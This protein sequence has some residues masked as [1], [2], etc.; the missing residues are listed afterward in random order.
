MIAGLG[1]WASVERRLRAL[2]FQDASGL[3]KE[4]P[5]PLRSVTRWGVGESERGDLDVQVPDPAIQRGDPAIQLGQNLLELTAAH[6]QP[7]LNDASGKGVGDGG[8]DPSVG[9]LTE[10]SKTAELPRAVTET[11]WRATSTGLRVVI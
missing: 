9:V 4:I 7:R 5:R 2:R 1:R 6:L 8:R 10:R 3:S 11:W